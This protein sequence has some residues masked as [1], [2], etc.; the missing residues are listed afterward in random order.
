MSVEL[1][2]N[3][4]LRLRCDGDDCERAFVPLRAFTEAKPLRERAAMYG[5][6]VKATPT[7]QTSFPVTDVA[8]GTNDLC[9]D[10]GRHPT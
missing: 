7:P 5:W 1:K 6:R 10:C 8:T 9:P 3:G 4:A 2:R